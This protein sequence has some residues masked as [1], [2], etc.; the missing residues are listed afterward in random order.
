MSQ[1]KVSQNLYIAAIESGRGKS[2]VLLGMMELL[3]NRVRRLG[4]RP[5]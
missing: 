1:N 4:F 5:Y 3:S 2:L